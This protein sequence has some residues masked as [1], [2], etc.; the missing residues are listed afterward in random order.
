MS[1]STLETP[2]QVLVTTEWLARRLDDPQIRVVEVDEDADAW[3][4]S[5]IPGA[6]A[7]H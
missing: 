4:R 7:W 6:V 5:H 1:N 3:G 2:N